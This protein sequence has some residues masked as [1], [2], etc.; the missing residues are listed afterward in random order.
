[1][2]DILKGDIYYA[3]LGPALLSE[4]GGVRP[5]VILQNNNGNKYSPNVIVAPLTSQEKNDLPT[6]VKLLKTNFPFLKRL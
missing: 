6:H 4:Q 2:R 5:V 3:D 1:M